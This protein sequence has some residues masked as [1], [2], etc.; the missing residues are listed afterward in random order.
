M[1]NILLVSA[2]G[3][4]TDFF[5]DML[6]RIP[7]E[8]LLTVTTGGEA[9]R[10]LVERAFDLCV[11]NSPLPDETGDKLAADII[12]EK[13]NQVILVVKQE[14]AYEITA[15]VEDFGVFTVEKPISR[16]TFW[17]ALKMAEASYKRLNTVQN[18]NIVLKRK[19]NDLKLINRAKCLLIEKLGVS[20]EDAHKQIE[21]EAMNLRVTRT[22]IAKEIINLYEE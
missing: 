4:M 15:K 20:E 7:Y 2:S 21:Q 5:I 17:T 19:L 13:A 8:E 1:L 6:T 3:N 16:S 11:I 22:E 9:R 12:G 10:L 18:E 14:I